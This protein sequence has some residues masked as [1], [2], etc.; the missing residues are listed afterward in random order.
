MKMSCYQIQA[1]SSLLTVLWR[2]IYEIVLPKSDICWQNENSQYMHL[3]TLTKS[4]QYCVSHAGMSLVIS[5]KQDH[6]HTLRVDSK[7]GSTMT[8]SLYCFLEFLR[9][10]QL[11]QT[12]RNAQ[13]FTSNTIQ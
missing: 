10:L 12:H 8:K 6:L 2:N 13:T 7:C 5:P 3:E 4:E 11:Q 1:Y 9:Y